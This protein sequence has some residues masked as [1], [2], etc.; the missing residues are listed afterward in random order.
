MS[1]VPFICWHA[2][3]RACGEAPLDVYRRAPARQCFSRSRSRSG[4]Y[5]LYRKI[6][7]ICSDVCHRVVQTS[8]A[9]LS[10]STLPSTQVNIVHQPNLH[11]LSRP[12]LLKVR[13]EYDRY[14]QKAQMLPHREQSRRFA[15]DSFLPANPGPVCTPARRASS[16]PTYSRA[17]AAH[18]IHA[19]PQSTPR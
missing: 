7:T 14:L 12:I 19:P 1:R 11:L 16:C 8:A 2:N 6:A 15:Q 5:A 17:S 9:P 4:Q 13:V 18:R 10:I 3:S